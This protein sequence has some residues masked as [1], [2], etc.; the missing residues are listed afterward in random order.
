[1]EMTPLQIASEY[2]TGKDK[3][4]TIKVLAELNAVTQR[5]IAQILDE[6]GEAL[7]GHWKEKLAQP[8]QRPP[9]ERIATAACALPRNDK[10]GPVT[11]K[12]LDEAIVEA[13][14]PENAEAVGRQVAAPTEGG[15]ALSLDEI[16]QAALALILDCGISEAERFQG[17]AKGIAALVA[18]LEERAEERIATP[19]TSVTGS[20]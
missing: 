13:V 9:K 11:K 7:P 5:T 8:L 16:R 19:V 14:T 10:E 15:A 20:Q 4:K 6:Q 17:F 1:M 12:E 3:T 18:E 2:R